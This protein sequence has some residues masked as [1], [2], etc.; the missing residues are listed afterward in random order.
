[1]RV[2]SNDQD[3]NSDSQNNT[4]LVISRCSHKASKPFTVHNKLGNTGNARLVRL[5]GNL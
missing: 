3:L 1:M 4:H 2:N 5:N